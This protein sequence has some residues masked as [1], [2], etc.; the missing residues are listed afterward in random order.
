MDSSPQDAEFSLSFSPPQHLTTMPPQ[1]RSKHPK[2]KSQ[3][4]SL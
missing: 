2:E 4:R 1:L 3:I